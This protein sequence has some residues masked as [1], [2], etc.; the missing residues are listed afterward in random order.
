MKIRSGFVSN[1]SSSSF[2]IEYKDSYQPIKVEGQDLSLNDLFDYID[3]ECCNYN[4]ETT[5][6]EITN[7]NDESKESLLEYIDYQ[8][9][10]V[11]DE[12]KQKLLNLKEDIKAN[13]S[14]FARFELSYH[15]KMGRF[16]FNIL[17]GRNVFTIRDEC[18][19]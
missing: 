1:S 17:K 15:D 5:V 14:T 18:E 13:E 16:I 9:Q 12:V 4:Y 3:H 11:D 6:H 19:Y 10:W 8:I 7:E 2:I